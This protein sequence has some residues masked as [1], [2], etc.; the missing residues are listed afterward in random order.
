MQIKKGMFNYLSEMIDK[1]RISPDVHYFSSEPRPY[2]KVS[3]LTKR[4]VD[5]GIIKK[6][7]FSSQLGKVEFWSDKDLNEI[8]SF[9]NAKYPLNY[10][11]LFS[12]REKIEKAN[13][14]VLTAKKIK[15][16]NAV[17]DISPLIIVD[18]VNTVFI[19]ENNEYVFASHHS[20]QK[21]H[22]TL[23]AMYSIE[24]ISKNTITKLVTPQL[25]EKDISD[26]M[27]PLRYAPEISLDPKFDTEGSKKVDRLI[28]KYG[29]AKIK[30]L[31]KYVALGLISI[32][33]L[34]EWRVKDQHKN[35]FYYDLSVDT[36]DDYFVPSESSV[37][38]E[39]PSSVTLSS[40][41]KRA[42]FR[43]IGKQMNGLTKSALLKAIPDDK[44]DGLKSFL[45]SE[46]GTS[47]VSMVSGLSLTYGLKENANAQILAQEL[48][49]NSLAIVGN[50]IVDTLME[51][52][53]KTVN[54]AVSEISV[55]EFISE[56]MNE[57]EQNKA[58]SI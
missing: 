12:I 1:V 16:S 10:D 38:E 4:L 19:F 53:F 33:D 36:D 47:F 25:S 31:D 41:P 58:L 11:S 5:A 52:V 2:E 24:K 43:I 15:E 29:T 56:E 39:I 22:A 7:D 32:K 9:L 55:E 27:S 21:K 48:R 18:D 54:E 42:M 30:E 57:P 44:V 6:E 17:K 14:S 37:P 13:D 26:W 23:D 3:D 46:L 20:L 50:E 35:N 8:T 28:D 45:E 49:V 34:K 40:E 51:N